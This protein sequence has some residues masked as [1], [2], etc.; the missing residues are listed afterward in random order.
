MT[1]TPWI[2]VLV[3]ILLSTGGCLVSE[4]D[5]EIVV[6]EIE[7][8]RLELDKQRQENHT[9][10]QAILEVYQDR[11]QL[12][13][14]LDEMSA[15][16]DAAKEARKKRAPEQIKYY[17]VRRGDTL[18]AI[19]NRT[20]VPAERLRELNTLRNDVVWVGQKLRIN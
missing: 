8:L 20:K 2:I 10:N 3:L 5:Y 16:L 13:A 19:A 17:T 4:N 1:R 12:L 7:T 18:L 6:S 14:R 11:Q 9:L 15:E